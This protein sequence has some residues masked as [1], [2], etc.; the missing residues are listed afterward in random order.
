MMVHGRDE[1]RVFLMSDP[2]GV[3][4]S[5]AVRRATVSI[6]VGPSVEIGC[7]REGRYHRGLSVHGDIDVIPPGVPSRWEIKEKDTA[8][9]LAVPHRLLSLA[10]EASG[11]DP[12][13]I[14]IANRFQIRDPQMEH[15]GWALKS[16]MEAGYPGGRLYFDSLAMALAAS[17]VERHGSGVAL[18]HYKYGMSGRTL[19]TVLGYIEDNLN[20][21]LSLREIAEVAGLSV[22]HCKTA[23]SKSVGT[24]IHQYV[25]QRRVERAKQLL[26]Q[27]ELTISQVAAEAGFTHK[28]HL[29]FHTR[30]MF[31]LSPTGL[32]RRAAGAS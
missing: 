17:L 10:A 15:I 8:L 31:G 29:A 22:S 25:I 30:R 7:H 11:A 14:Q 13:K 20:R 6:H 32:R 26:A 12:A 16:E 18:A 2:P 27:D 9:I 5:P 3:V 24:P 28:S 4:D 21:E 23:F 1:L 19:R